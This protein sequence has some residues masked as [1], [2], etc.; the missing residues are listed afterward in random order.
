MQHDANF[1]LLSSFSSSN[2]VKYCATRGEFFFFFFGSRLHIW[3]CRSRLPTAYRHMSGGV[4][5][6]GVWKNAS[7]HMAQSWKCPWLSAVSCC[8]A[9][10][11]KGGD[12]HTVTMLN[13]MGKKRATSLDSSATSPRRGYLE[14]SQDTKQ[15]RCKT[16]RVQC[17]VNSSSG[18]ANANPVCQS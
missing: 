10:H 11:Q 17:D 4:N 5:G 18:I 13:Y 6:D 12:V 8:D 14:H 9:T 16:R 15:P 1:C 2:E 3:D 7:Q